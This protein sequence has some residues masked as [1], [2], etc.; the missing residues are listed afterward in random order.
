[1]ATVTCHYGTGGCQPIGE[2]EQTKSLRNLR[3]QPGSP[4][5]GLKGYCDVFHK[6]RDIDE[7]GPL[8]RLQR[9][10]FGSQSIGAIRDLIT[11]HPIVAGIIFI[12][13]LS[14]LVLL[15]RCFA[16]HTPT[17]NPHKK[18][19]QKLRNTMKHPMNIF[20]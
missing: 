11:K 5:N 16:V 7:E 20:K 6:C 10:F 19:A 2:F 15:F 12:V 9:I 13:F 8:T 17:S 18:Q 4:C 14:F 3:L 1:M